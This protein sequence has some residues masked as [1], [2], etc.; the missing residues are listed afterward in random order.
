[1]AQ[2]VKGKISNP[3][4]L[5]GIWDFLISVLS[6]SDLLTQTYFRGNF[7]RHPVWHFGRFPVDFVDLGDKM[8]LNATKLTI[9]T[10]RICDRFVGMPIIFSNDSEDVTKMPSRICKRIEDWNGG[11]RIHTECELRYET[12]V[13]TFFLVPDKETAEYIEGSGTIPGVRYRLQADTSIFGINARVLEYEARIAKLENGLAEELILR[14]P[15]SCEFAKKKGWVKGKPVFAQFLRELSKSSRAGSC[16]CDD[17]TL[18]PTNEL[19]KY[20]FSSIGDLTRQMSDLAVAWKGAIRIEVVPRLKM[21][22]SIKFFA[23]G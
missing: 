22:I 15:K 14:I 3:K 21:A 5:F 23:I 8:L 6:R 1:M 20:G 17:I 7:E 19:A 2:F 4:F 12:E 16:E 9:S 13:L 11:I 18:W 10:S